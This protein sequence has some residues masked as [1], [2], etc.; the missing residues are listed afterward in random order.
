[1]IFSHL[2]LREIII[3]GNSHP[4]V[5]THIA[6]LDYTSVETADGL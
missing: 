5:Y 1:M 6:G 3:P 4:S 2:I